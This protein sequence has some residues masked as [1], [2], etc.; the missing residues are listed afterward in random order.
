MVVS[1]TFSQSYEKEERTGPGGKKNDF[2]KSRFRKPTLS[3]QR[4]EMFVYLF[5]RFSNELSDAFDS[6]D[7]P[8]LAQ[9]T[10]DG[11]LGVPPPIGIG[12]YI[13]LNPISDSQ[14]KE[15]KKMSDYVF[16]YPSKKNANYLHDLVEIQLL[17]HAGSIKQEDVYKFKEAYE[18][19]RN[20]LDY[21]KD[22]EFGSA[23]SQQG[24][25]QGLGQGH[26]LGTEGIITT[27]TRLNPDYIYMLSVFFMFMQ[28]GL[29]IPP[30]SL[31][32]I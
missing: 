17:Q 27:N 2:E 20:V 31:V 23:E 3:K 6:V 7:L 19:Q 26:G 8:E 16:Q 9:K 21:V 10:R 25:G 32:M 11:I 13:E 14:M 24:Q 1:N 12:E 30:S 22:E 29:K 28:R 15:C 5:K 18:R 4:E